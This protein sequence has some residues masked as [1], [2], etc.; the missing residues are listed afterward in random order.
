M[1]DSLQMHVNIHSL[2][3]QLF[4]VHSGKGETRHNEEQDYWNKGTKFR[5]SYICTYFSNL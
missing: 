4:C 1:I 2:S 3:I 5:S